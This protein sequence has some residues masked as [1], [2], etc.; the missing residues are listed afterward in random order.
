MNGRWWWL[1]GAALFSALFSIVLDVYTPLHAEFWWC[2]L[3]FLILLFTI[4]AL[5][6]AKRKT[7]IDLA[8]A[9]V[10]GF[11]IRFLAGLIFLLVV[12]LL[13]KGGFLYFAI[14]FIGQWL[15]FTLAEIAYLT[16]L[17]NTSRK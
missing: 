11:V 10:A 13:Q 1:G 16:R 2:S 4:L 14:H 6:Y 3:L 9:L 12:Y 5:V 15:L 17:Y 8:P 7:A